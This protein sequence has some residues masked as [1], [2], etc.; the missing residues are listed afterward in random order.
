[1]FHWIC[2]ECG[3]EIPPAMKECPAC[4]PKAAPVATAPP[5]PE[6]VKSSPLEQATPEKPAVPETRISA[7][8]PLPVPAQPA[9]ILSEPE[10][11]PLLAM[12]EQIRSAQGGYAA[13]PV[14]EP[15]PEPV[16]SAPEQP[17]MVGLAQLAAVLGTATSPGV[18][19]ALEAPV[20]PIPAPA[21]GAPPRPI[22]PYPLALA[23][24]SQ[25]IAL[26][27]P[28]ETA[29]AAP[30]EQ[31]V[32]AA[33]LA[34]VASALAAVDAPVVSLQAAPMAVETP[35]LQTDPHPEARTEE[36]E[37]LV[38]QTEA[39]PAAQT[40]EAPETP[41]QR[42]EAESSAQIV[43]APVAP[44]AVEA[45]VEPAEAQPPALAV[46]AP[47]APAAEEVPVLKSEAQPV[48]APAPAAPVAQDTPL[49]ELDKPQPA[50]PAVEAQATPPPPLNDLYPPLLKELSAAQEVPAK[51]NPPSGSRLQLAPLQDYASTAG[52]AFRPAAPPAQI[53][54]PDSGPRM[55]LPGPALPPGLVSLQSAKVVTVIGDEKSPGK[56]RMPGWVISA[57][58]MLGIPIAGGLLLLYFQ[59][60]QH[61]SADA[62]PAEEVQVPAIPAAASHSL[63]QFVEVTGFRIVVDFNKK[64]EIHYLVVNHSAADLSDMT[65]YVTVRNASAKPGQPPVTRFSFRA[66]GL[67]PFGSKEMS[68]P[69]EKLNRSITLP[70]WQDLRAEVQI[71]Q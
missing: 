63:A 8:P 61:S 58:L 50:A 71:G 41:G 60:L 56:R 44:A 22:T 31:Q 48:Q 17:E 9:K 14:A 65:L 23:P 30:A 57:L 33:P 32:A 26:L 54:S 18:G 11:D 6:A 69:I 16:A 39:Q 42:N 21:A 51:D 10:A 35:M 62:T 52:R 67:G 25:A 2:P 1:M 70:D 49:S 24:G 34:P 68:S 38:L 13:P 36:A 37:T 46:E 4:D 28:P 43:E 3:R 47:V 40:V 5:V 53:L 19:P 55:T 27:A 64:S 20:K 59:P 45:S 29:A 15:R 66:P 7:A 12:A